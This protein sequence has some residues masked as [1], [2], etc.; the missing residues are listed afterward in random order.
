MVIDL[1]SAFSKAAEDSGTTTSLSDIFEEEP[2]PFHTFLNDKKYLGLRNINLSDIQLNAL[3]HIERIYYPDLYPLMAEEFNEPYWN[4]EIPMRNLITVQWGKGC[5]SPDQEVFSSSDGKWRK[6][7]E[8]R[9]SHRVSGILDTEPGKLSDHSDGDATLTRGTTI[10]S[11]TSR[12]PFKRGHGRMLRVTTTSG[13][14]IDVFEGHLFV[15]WENHDLPYKN[16]YKRAKPIWRAAGALSVGDRIAIASN[17]NVENTVPQDLREV[18]LVGY[19]IGDGSMPGKGNYDL[20][21]SVD[22]GPDGE[23]MSARYRELVSTFPDAG[24]REYSMDSG[25]TGIVVSGKGKGHPSIFNEIVRRYGLWGKHAWDKRVPEQMFSLPDDQLNTFIS[26][27]WQTDG[28]IY[29]KVTT[30]STK[31]AFEY[32]TTSEGLARDIQRLLLRLGVVSRIRSKKTS[33]TYKGEKKT[34]RTAWTVTVVSDQDVKT[35]AGKLSLLGKKEELRQEALLVECLRAQQTGQGDIRW[36]SVKSIEELGDGDYWDMQV[37]GQGT[38][39]AGSIGF[40]N[41]NSGKDMICRWAALRIAYL[42]ICLKSPQEYFGLPDFDSIHMLN[43][44]SSAPQARTAF[45]KPMTV[46]VKRGWFSDKA[47]PKQGLIEF[48]KN[49]EAISGHSEAES[50]E[51]LNLILG[52]A[53]EIDAFKTKEEMTMGGRHREAS[54][55]AETILDMLK[56]SAST[57]FPDTYKR[58]AISYPRYLGST[59]Q[60]LTKEGRDSNERYGDTSRHFVSGPF[61]TWEVNPRVVGKEKYSEDYDNDPLGSAAKYEC[62]PS[63]ATDPY[64]KNKEIFRQA[65]TD[66]KQP[67]AINYKRTILKSDVTSEETEVWDIEFEFDDNFTAKEG[68]IYAMHADLAIKQDR[69]G[70]SLAHVS[71]W[72]EKEETLVAEDGS[73]Y[74]EVSSLPEVT[75]DFVTSF[76][77]DPKETPPREIQISWARKLAFELIKRGFNITRFTFDAFQ[78]ADSM[79][80]LESH[81]I[82]TERVSM[83]INDKGWQNLRDVASGGRLKMPFSQSLFDELEALSKTRGKVDHPPGGSKDEADSLAGAVLGA[84]VCGGEESA[85]GNSVKLMGPE[86]DVYGR[87]EDGSDLAENFGNV[88]LM[89]MPLG[90]DGVGFNGFR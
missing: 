73:H 51:G 7:S 41:A 83:D 81:G 2:V 52:V 12:E 11:A 80:I 53:D 57:R 23:A 75:V 40:I 64:F 63:R 59:I 18:E 10:H 62:K 9:G 15:S 86:T 61:A 29:R 34:G 1:S 88:S 8:I 22:S 68:A 27:L 65:V 35:L 32:A 67:I 76:S 66:P 44:A 31:F 77:A 28:S 47:E 42:L 43:I 5:L 85:D 49:V 25:A 30:S 46:A 89:G 74:I 69:A 38:Y 13:G 48:D 17:L 20:H 72:I 4:A 71:R 60:K 39:V 14:T 19:W 37:P 56:T 6:V 87:F 50:Q 26:A 70:I 79:Q 3:R 78:S 21:F 54:T 55:S 90:M 84:I 16:R 45:F 36:D 33:Y 82:E 24:Y 58:V